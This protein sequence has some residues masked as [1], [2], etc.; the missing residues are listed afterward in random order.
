MTLSHDRDGELESLLR[1]SSPDSAIDTFP[2][3]TPT[4]TRTATA[5]EE[6]PLLQAAGD[7]PSPGPAPSKAFQYKVTILCAVLVFVL[8]VAVFIMESPFQVI[9]EDV[10]CHNRYPDHVPRRVHSGPFDKDNHPDF[11]CKG[12]AVQKT[13]AAVRSISM[14]PQLL[15]RT[16]RPAD[17]PIL[18]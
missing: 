2:T 10:I 11:R 16:F 15:C 9:M 3:M 7:A 14:I 4:A 18:G 8:D 6:E 13:M 12:A 17:T 5:A 1:P